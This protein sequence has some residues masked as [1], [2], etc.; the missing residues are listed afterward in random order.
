MLL[1]N[2]IEYRLDQLNNK[3]M[4]AAVNLTLQLF[5]NRYQKKYLISFLGHSPQN[6]RP[7]NFLWN[8]METI[9]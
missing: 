1:V 6:N 8:W 5:E 9:F 4:K 2:S 7:V 3:H